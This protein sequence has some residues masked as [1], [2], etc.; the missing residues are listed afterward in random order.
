MNK[1][2]QIDIKLEI[3]AE[4]TQVF[5]PIWSADTVSDGVLSPVSGQHLRVARERLV[6]T[7]GLA[8]VSDLALKKRNSKNKRNEDI[9][10]QH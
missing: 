7:P 1:R 5:L 2:D 4:V 8:W 6:L 9:K 3:I 10:D